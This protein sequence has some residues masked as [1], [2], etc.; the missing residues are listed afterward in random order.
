MKRTHIITTLLVAATLAAGSASAQTL[1]VTVGQVTYQVP[2]AQAGN[3]TYSNGS[4]LTIMG[5]TFDLA[6]VDRM[7]V[8]DT[9]V[10][11]GAVGVSYNDSTATVTVAGN[12]MQ[13][14]T[15]VAS[16]S[17]VSI[18]Q[19]ADLPKEVTYT[20]TGSSQAGSFYMDGELKAT[21]VLS[22]LT[23][24][25]ADS[26]AIN[27][28][29]GK[30]IAVQLVGTNTLTDGAKASSKGAMMVNGHT[31]FTGAGTLTLYGLAKHGFWGDEY[32]E[33]KKAMTGTI[34]VASAKKDGFNINQYLEQKGG[35]IVISNV[36]DD[37]I[38]VAA[39]SDSTDEQNGQVIIKGGTIQA[40]TSATAAKAIKA[41]GN[42][43]ISGGTVTAK[44]TGGG[45]W[46]SD[47]AKAKAAACLSSDA[48]V[49]ISGGTINLTATGAGGKGIN[50]DSTVNISGGDITI[51]TSGNIYV[52][53]NGTEY[54]NYTGNTDNLSSDYTSSPKGIKAD[55]NVY[56]SDGTISVTTT[57]TNAEGIESKAEL[58][59]SGGTVNVSAYDDGI[60]SSSHMHI[61]GGTINVT[62][63]DNDALDSNGN[64]YFTG[65]NIQAFGSRSPECG[66]DANEE[67][68]YSVYFQGGSLLAVGGS[69]S[70]P[71]SSQSTQPYVTVSGSINKGDVVTLKSGD[72]V[73]ATF[74]A[75]KTFS[76]SSSG[77]GGRPGGGP[78]GQSS[79]GILITAPGMTSGSTYTVTIGSTSTT[80]TARTTGSSGGRW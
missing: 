11:D 51:T 6:S 29:D 47:D 68:G 41:D 9:E 16:G 79:G 40:T 36:G 3:M 39:T 56:I 2:A 15:V 70:V 43:T 52:N 31:E 78:G 66:I 13:Y 71:S 38:Q 8:D 48:N 57:G 33:L 49:I 12:V 45:E 72:T 76:S 74:T 18:V 54:S 25:N 26:A 73:L 42:I 61:S 44:V 64:M 17:H 14:L 55:G 27:I 34:T 77:G 21:L 19:S 62:S 28:E 46:D 75:I 60:N 10:T 7:W 67:G 22:N 58:Y 80:A 1:N 32:V 59:I 53:I 50:A 20:L 30:R 37:A 65:G 35:N 5:K 69:N 4:Q 63:S 24:T 23:L